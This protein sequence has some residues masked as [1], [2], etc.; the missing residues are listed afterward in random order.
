[1]GRIALRITDMYYRTV[2]KYSF[3]RRNQDA[4]EAAT[5]LQECPYQPTAEAV[6]AV[7]GSHDER[8]QRYVAGTPEITAGCRRI[9]AGDGPDAWFACFVVDDEVDGA[10]PYAK[11]HRSVEKTFSAGWERMEA[12]EAPEIVDDWREAYHGFAAIDETVAATSILIDEEVFR[13]G[14]ELGPEMTWYAVMTGVAAHKAGIEDEAAVRDIALA[15]LPLL[16]ARARK[17]VT[18][19]FSDENYYNHIDCGAAELTERGRLALPYRFYREGDAD[20]P[21]PAGKTVGCVADLVKL[22]PQDEF[23]VLQNCMFACINKQYELGLLHPQLAYETWEL[24][25]AVRQRLEAEVKE[26]ERMGW[27]RTAIEQYAYSELRSIL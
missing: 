18:H 27:M 10:F 21:E 15:N 24:C 6:R 14:V 4:R 12:E 8:L 11:F 3:R 25:Q 19:T 26:L 1:M 2:E 20:A 7:A 5:A 16:V 22:Y 17:N 13:R 23:S 9:I